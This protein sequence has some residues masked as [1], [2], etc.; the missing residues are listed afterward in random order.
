M[1][2][3]SVSAFSFAMMRAGFPARACSASRSILAISSLC[4]ENGVVRHRH[5]H[6][7][8]LSYQNVDD[9]KAALDALPAPAG[10]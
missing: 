10:A 3:G 4:S 8:G 5:D 9:L 2:C 1:I 7:L 6:L